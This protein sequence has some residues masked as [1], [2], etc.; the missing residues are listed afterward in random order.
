M[1]DL[2]LR[3]HVLDE[4]SFEPSINAADVGVSVTDGIATLTG[5]VATHA[6][7]IAAEKAVRRVKGIRGLVQDIEVRHRGADML[8]DEHLAQRAVQLLDWDVL[9]PRNAVQVKVQDG[10]ITLTGEVEWQ[11]Q[12]TA[13]GE[14]LHR[15]DHVKGVA[16]QIA[17]KPQA[18]AADIRHRI[19]EAL[20]RSAQIDADTITVM[21]R[22]GQVT[23]NGRVRA[24]HERQ[25][26]ERAAWSAPGVKAVDDRLAISGY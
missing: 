19:Q 11:F 20:K 9:V 4:L 15:L 6:E 3:K 2:A 8:C 10:W 5:H 13:A 16:N 25:I 17:V 24:W 23:L 12:K 14:S 1:T 26:A 18:N 21:V 7:K 22:D